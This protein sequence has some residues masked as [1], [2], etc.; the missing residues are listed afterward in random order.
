MI[1]DVRYALRTLRKAPGFTLVAVLTLGLG[2]GATTAIYSVIDTILLQPLPFADSDRLVRVVQ[3]EPPFRAGG[4]PAQRGLTW[5]EFVDWRARTRT[6][7]DTIGFAHNIGMVETSQGTVRMW[8]AMTS[9]STFTMLGA[10]AMLGRT[11]VE[12]DDANPNVVVL[13]IDAWRR[14]FR[15]APDAVGKSVRFDSVH[16]GSRLMTVVGVMPAD[17]EFPIEHME[18]FTPF[19][20]GDESGKKPGAITLIGRVRPDVT[21]EAAVQEAM[22]IGTAVTPPPAADAQP[23]AAPR[24]ELRNVKAEMIRELRPALRVFL[25]AVAVV[26]MIVC[27]NVANLLLARGTARQR[28][29]AVRVAIG[30]SR[31]RLV[32]QVLT[33]CLVLATAGGLLGALVGALGV[34]LVKQLAF[35]EAPG[36]FRLMFGASILPRVHEVGINSR[37]FGI[38]FGISAIASVA[39]GLLPALHLSRQNPVQAFTARGGS[40]GR[41]ASKLRAALVVAQL[42]MA[43]VLL[44]GAGLLIQ[45]F[46]RLLA[47]D[48]GYNPSNVLAF[49]L[50]FPPEYAIARK[51]DTIEG[52]LTRLRATPDVVAAGFARHG[53]LIGEKITIGTFIPQG[54]TPEQMRANPGWP[55][56][57]PVS[58]GYLS[59][60]RAR[61]LA[62]T[63][64]NPL[65]SGS[66]PAI[67]ISE[68]TAR[69]FGPGRPG[70]KI[71][72]VV[73]WQFG[74]RLFPLQIV[75]VVN[76]VRNEKAESEPYPE[77]FIDY[78]DVLKMMTQFGDKPARQE[79]TALG[80]LSFSVRTRGE[81]AEAVSMVSR[82]VRE[83]DPNA[84]ID[85]IAPLEQLVSSSV[86][87]PRFYAVLLGLFAS[88]A[89]LLAAIGIYGVLAYAVTQRTQEIGIR[90]ALGAQ[91]RQVLAIVLRRALWLTVVGLT[92]GLAGAAGVTRFLEGM[93]F[94]VTPLDRATFVAVSILFGLVAV[95]ASYIPARRATKVDPMTAL[96]TE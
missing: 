32:R 33:E 17:F 18:F 66:P 72:R 15:S 3:N 28:E 60:V 49:Q 52:I 9:G 30:A 67:V 12:S 2:I 88:I 19:T 59:A 8:G 48:R 13:S 42:V 73:D 10:R 26:L 85:A 37:M 7:S 90:M 79:Q 39:F 83:V 11:L 1:Q 91:R 96:R 51:V 87:R 45:S 23:M 78:R 92:L 54:R 6:F 31:W 56:V 69:I 20:L 24:F 84:G 75:G 95:L 29:M 68:S 76:D 86:A 21:M 35:V 81:P 25:V 89:G 44:I 64:L 80:L 57:R 65:D 93:L 71:G 43:T 55:S 50:V 36:I 58:G 46:G 82:I 40:A 38:A 74:G 47:V 27:A 62:G 77:V 16:G 34:M 53:V 14:V 63:D 94:G 4:R 70:Q 41:G 5:Q 22:V 61:M